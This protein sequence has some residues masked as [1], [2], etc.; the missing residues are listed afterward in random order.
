LMKQSVRIDLNLL[1]YAMSQKRK[2][3]RA[4]A[5]LLKLASVSGAT[6]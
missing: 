2:T 4:E 6:L 5:T 3:L 1:V